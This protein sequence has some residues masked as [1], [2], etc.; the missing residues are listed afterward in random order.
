[1]EPDIDKEDDS[2]DLS[3][4]ERHST[5]EPTNELIGERLLEEEYSLSNSKKGRQQLEDMNP[6]KNAQMQTSTHRMEGNH[7][8]AANFQTGNT[9]HNAGLLCR[10][11]T[12]SQRRES[13]IP[14]PSRNK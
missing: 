7:I 8:L 1:M 14:V 2:F 3:D 4:T 5:H 12:P 11:A 10:P 13:H 6:S 9:L